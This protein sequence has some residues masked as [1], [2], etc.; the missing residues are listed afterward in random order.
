MTT[1]FKFYISFILLV[2]SYT[3]TNA[4][5]YNDEEKE[6]DKTPCG[7]TERWSVKVLTDAAS[8]QVNYTPVLTTINNL[9]N[10]A[11]PSTST[12]AARFTGLEYTTYKIKCKLSQVRDESDNDFHL[13]VTDGTHFMITEI[14]DPLCAV[15]STSAHVNEY[16]AARQFVSTY[17]PIIP[18]LQV[19]LPDVSITGVA[20]LDPPHGQSGEAPNH[21]ELHPILDIHFW[22]SADSTTDAVDNIS[23]PEPLLTVNIFPNKF[24]NSAQLNVKTKDPILG[25][26]SFELY[27]SD[28]NKVNEMNL[29][30]T[31]K[32]EI[33]YTIH[34]GN[35]TSGLYIYRIRNNNKLMYDGKLIIE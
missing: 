19:T 3:I 10:I 2:L 11:T 15:A 8:T 33:K 17:V 24:A 28:G 14:P 18:N 22:T 12:T 4:Q 34:R 1:R 29:P 35:L 30:I 21:L 31:N 23:M 27:S 26:C 20:F 32:N 25:N 5:T 16:V 13:V 9:I 6:M 7:G